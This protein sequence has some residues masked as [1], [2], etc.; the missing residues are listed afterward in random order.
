MALT[1]G[2]NRQALTQEAVSLL[3]T[4]RLNE[5]RINKQNFTKASHIPHP[6][7]LNKN[8][9]GREGKGR[10]WPFQQTWNFTTDAT[11]AFH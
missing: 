1:K 3:S 2:V 7:E 8:K 10:V 9:A 11:F 4:G 6:P 5:S